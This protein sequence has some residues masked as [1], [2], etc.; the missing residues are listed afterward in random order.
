MSIGNKEVR[1]LKQTSSEKWL[2]EKEKKIT[3]GY[4]VSFLLLV[5]A[6]ICLS[7][8]PNA[9]AADITLTPKIGLATGYE[10]NIM[11]SREE[12]VDSTIISAMPG[13]ILNYDTLVSSA[14][15]IADF[16]IAHYIDETDL[17]YV[18]QYY[19]AHGDYRVS[20][21]WKIKAGF[22]FKKDT[23]L[24]SYLEETGRVV[25]R[26]DRLYT[27][28]SAGFSYEISKTSSIDTDYRFEKIQYEKDLYQDYERHRLDV[29]YRHQLKSIQDTILVGPSFYHRENDLSDV[30]YASVDFGWLRN[31]DAITSTFA[32]VGARYT[33]EKY[34]ITGENRDGI[35]AR[36]RVELTRRGVSSTIEFHYY[37]DLATLADGTDVN[38]DNFRVIYDYLLTARIGA[39]I[40]AHLVL[41]YKSSSS[42]NRD[43]QDN[44]YYFLEPYVYYQLTKNSALYLHYSYQNSSAD[45]IDSVDPWERNKIWIEYRF[46][47]PM[48]F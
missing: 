47:V 14:Q 34:N 45:L 42:Q 15:M 18:N 32:T 7:L 25:Q 40:N 16:D 28:P 3:W 26:I 4:F 27:N 6:A 5:I 11:Y 20:N 10:D 36:A 8:T 21:R 43:T 2:P 29:R 37:H 30:D 38:V 23:M 35:G 13:L 33:N 9:R 41:S 46:E 31:W 17:D 19:N 39:G 12:K 24:N 1:A 44:R 22:N 48:K